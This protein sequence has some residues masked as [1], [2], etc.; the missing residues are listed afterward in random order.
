[1]IQ[2][3]LVAVDGSENSERALDFA[4]DFA[5][6]YSA[7]LTVL[8]VTEVAATVYSGD[9]MM[10]VAKDL[11]KLHEAI[12][13]RAVA[14]VKITKPSLIVWP[15]LREGDPAIEI[16]ATAKEGE[17]D[18]VVLGH[19]G[20]GKVKGIL[21]GSISGKVTRLLSCTVVIVK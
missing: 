4:L 13:D 3:V 11:H 15:V 1:M 17:F 6:K 21:L 14:H 7:S 12:L 19:Q 10:T 2:K 5:E 18:A 20:V 8:N 16:V 9:E